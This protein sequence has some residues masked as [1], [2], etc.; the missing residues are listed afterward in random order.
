MPSGVLGVSPVENQVHL[1][2]HAPKQM[3]R[4]IIGQTRATGH[5][6]HGGIRV[7]YQDGWGLC[8]PSNTTPAL[9]MRFEGKDETALARIKAVFNDALRRVAPDIELP[10]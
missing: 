5:A 10:D 9:V 2:R 8:R 7:D 6:R 1:V 3:S 4:P